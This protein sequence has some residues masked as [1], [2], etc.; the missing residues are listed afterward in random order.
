MTEHELFSMLQ[1]EG[2]AMYNLLTQINE[3]IDVIGKQS[4]V[5]ANQVENIDKGND[6][7]DKQLDDHEQRIRILEV[8]DGR[9]N[10]VFKGIG[11]GGRVVLVLSGAGGVGG[12]IALF[13]SLGG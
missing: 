8:Q 6:R 13:R 11:I 12:L 10:G 3:K 4:A 5:I 9:N 1:G 7:R 2:G